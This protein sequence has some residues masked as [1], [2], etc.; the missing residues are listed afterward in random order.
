ML[1][2]EHKT[3]ILIYEITGRFPDQTDTELHGNLPSVGLASQEDEI[4]HKC[5][6]EIHS[7]SFFASPQPFIA[8]AH[9]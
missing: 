6:D 2:S 7:M 8:Q 9:L 3:Q 1:L 4:T 5:L